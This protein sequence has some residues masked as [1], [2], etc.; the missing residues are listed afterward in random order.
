MVPESI[1][2]IDLWQS[3]E[4]DSFGAF[5]GSANSN[6][7]GLVA[8]LKRAVHYADIRTGE[9][10]IDRRAFFFGLLSYGLLDNP[11]TSFGNT[12]TWV[13]NWIVSRAG[14]TLVSTVQGSVTGTD[15]VL[16]AY[17]SSKSVVTEVLRPLVIASQSM[18]SVTQLAVQYAQQTVG[19]DVADL[20]HFFA[21][22]LESP[23]AVE[24]VTASG[25][26]PTGD[27]INKLRQEL[28]DRIRTNPES[29]ERM[30][31][32]GQILLG[33][34][35]RDDGPKLSQPM[36]SE[37]SGFTSDRVGTSAADGDPLEL[38]S[39]VRAFARLICL[40]E[41]EPPLSIGLFGGWGSGKST[42]MQLL[43]NEIDALTMKTRAAAKTSVET[44]TDK[45]AIPAPSFIRNVVQIR[46]NAWHFAD[47]NL[48]ASLTAEFF[49]QLRAGGYARSGQ[50]IHT[51]LVE[52]VNAH[53]HVLS[54]E[55]MSARQ[56][57][58]A[59]ETALQD[60]QKARDKTVADVESV[61]GHAVKQTVVDAVT[62][63]F[64]EH[65]ADLGEMGLGT[66]KDEDIKDFI[67]L[68]KRLQTA[69]GQFCALL[70]FVFARGWRAFFATAGVVAALVS[71]WFVWPND[72]TRGMFQFRPLS[73]FGLLAGLGAF[74][75][76]VLP[77]V[78]IIGGLIEST[79]GFATHLDESLKVEIAKVAQAEE[80][81]KRATIEA[82]ARRTAAE[83]AGKALA[84]YVDPSSKVAN[85]PR[86]LRFM[87]EDDPDTRAMEKEVGLIS[88]VRRL[89][90]AVD[91][92]VQEEKQKDVKP[93]TQKD[94]NAAQ[95][96]KWRDPDVPDRIVIYIDDLDRC[97]PEQ[98]YAVLQA[99]HLLLAFKLF[100][101]VVGVDVAWVQ[102]ALA[103]ELRPTLNRA[104]STNE[105]KKSEIDERKLAIRY[106]EKIFQL[107]FW[108]R[109]LSTEGKDGG[110]YGRFIRALLARNLMARG[111]GP[112][113]TTADPSENSGSGGDQHEETVR[114]NNNRPT[115]PSNVSAQEDLQQPTNDTGLEEA[116][117]TVQLTT[118]EVDF[119]ASEAVGNLSG[120]EP[121][122]V[123]RFVNI[124][125]II[126]ARLT[127]DQRNLFLGGGGTP[128][129][130]PLV[131]ILIAVETGQ[132]ME[133]ADQFYSKL[134][135]SSQDGPIVGDSNPGISA[136]IREAQKIRGGADIS[137][138]DCAPWAQLVRRYSFNKY[139]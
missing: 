64:E 134:A 125:R 96:E 29:E 118:G 39:D 133:I 25:W 43:E 48:W 91:E 18:Q 82:D 24:D 113:R 67:D 3:I 19:R 10:V 128:A 93:G 97:T 47:A 22:F 89:F 87:L 88:R 74:A 27:D 106:L 114:A 119:L 32:W 109:R 57:L 138:R 135:D 41:A 42:F 37:I 8:T 50:R 31:A 115:A 26:T 5:D 75:R 44:P 79:A 98:V 120:R 121:R 51:Q 66:S 13:A 52:R 132:T 71:L 7:P 20:R 15:A 112:L 4:E 60:A 127:P 65:K 55:A 92:I 11:S 12:A 6:A 108:L 62:K 78:K 70:T 117:A 1:P 73:I 77:G 137:R 100:V 34:K 68:S 76:A 95:P 35:P 46:F 38:L 104:V 103:H 105:G 61:S 85:P 81:L 21:A 94:G 99:I 90:Q 72:L 123:K 49:D 83:R 86:L 9:V 14:Q 101:V 23:A 84:R 130:Y 122:T 59:S 126:R 111:P 136:A 16:N 33:P 102:E 139:N 107:P 80:K 28:Y 36:R 110:S 63:A 131:A 58:L 30:D 69:S 54:S 56:A 45:G 17:Q 40:E 124:Y 2:D 116:L 53:V 129:D